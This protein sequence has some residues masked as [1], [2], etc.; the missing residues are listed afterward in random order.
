MAKGKKKSVASG[1]PHKK[2]GQKRKLHHCWSSTM[3]MHLAKAG[4]LDKYNN[5]ES[6]TLAIQSRGKR[7][8]SKNDFNEFVK[9]SS[10]EKDN[11]FKNIKKK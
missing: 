1:G 3:R 6:W 2:H 8:A 10:E 7:D 11:Y 9:L 4:L 5:Y